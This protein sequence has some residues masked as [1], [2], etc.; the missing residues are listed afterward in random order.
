MATI[1]NDKDKILQAAAVRLP[2]SLG[3]GIYFSNPAP[4][5]RT[6]AS[7]GAQPS[8]YVIEAKF[9]G[10]IT[11]TVTWSVVSGTVSTAGISGNTWN[12]AY[13]DLSS[14]S[15][16]IRATLVYLGTTYSN[17]LTVSRISDA[18]SVGLTTQTQ[19]FTYTSAGTAPS[20]TSSTVTATAYNM[21]GVAYF[22]FLVGGTSVQNST[23]PTLNYTPAAA[24][25]GMPQQIT[26]QLREGSSN[27]VVIATSTLSMQASKPGVSPVTV[28]LSNESHVF[29]ANADGS[30]V[31]YGNSGTTIRVLSGL[32]ALD[33]DGLG[34][35]P[36]TWK[37]TTTSTFI[38]TGAITDGGFFA[39]VAD[40]SEF[41]T[42]QN[43]ASVVYTITGKTSEGVAF[44]VERFQ[45]F[46]KAIAGVLG[47][48]GPAGDKSV[49]VQLYQWSTAQPANPSGTSTFNWDTGAHSGY[50]GTNG[51]QVSVPPNP[52]TQ[53]IKL[54]SATKIS[55]A[56]GTAST[57]TITWAGG[58]TVTDI[59][60]NGAAGAQVAKAAIYRWAFSPPG[61]LSGSATYTWSSGAISS[62]PSDEWSLAPGSPTSPGMTLY[63]AEVNVTDTATATTTAFIWT[64]ASISA[65]GYAGT[66]GTNGKNG[67]D[68]VG[69]QGSQGVSARY[70]YARINTTNV[71]V[72][73]TYTV[74][75]DSSPS[76]TNTW[77]ASFN[78]SWSTIDPD[79]S[80]A[81]TLYQADGL[82]N[83]ANNQTTWT[84]PYIS[85][86]KVG[87]LQAV[88]TNTGNLTVTGDF[89]AGTAQ[90][91]GTT[92]TGEGGILKSGGNFAFGNATTNISF[93]G[94]QLTLN[95][96]V[97]N[98]ANIG[99]NQV[100]D[101]Y[102]TTTETGFTLSLSVTVP[103][104][105]SGAVILVGLG[106][107]KVEG[108]KD[109]SSGPAYGT[110]KSGSTVL[111]SGT[112][113]VIYA[114]S[115]PVATTYALNVQRFYPSFS[116]YESFTAP[117]TLTVQVIKR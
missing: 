105:S 25:S 99:Q 79:P 94:T 77:G 100:N 22:E 64:A 66:N 56:V 85:S 53:L 9:N 111:A 106:S 110:L 18:R 33:Y 23:S 38:T 61:E 103:A 101:V 98:T 49:T 71:P 35:A 31:S 7:G 40:H 58:Y 69:S 19:T 4:V 13:G 74:G 24:F 12:L 117:L 89:K 92:M 108:G 113:A 107:Y 73:G 42:S 86:L 46:T 41:D 93:N 72:S 6:L 26:V 60:Q 65:V 8:N 54:W 2:A 112:G 91:S 80:S 29:P 114:I 55:A 16:V 115:N 32:T 47:E 109:I 48:D 70:A 10:Q 76:F 88:S 96:N 97:V 45:T 63:K 82:Y 11:G 3:N 52:G 87:N 36:G 59:T 30:V 95:G 14:D 83:P 62:V 28:Y 21:A 1:V 78:T 27:S 84:T 20:P 116:G 15:A 5:F 104:N 51:W 90:V 81:F 43:I 34:T 67:T 37:V 68:G 39:T 44:T 57:T 102:I 17:Q 75:G 50:T